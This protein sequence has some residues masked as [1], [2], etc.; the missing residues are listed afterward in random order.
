MGAGGTPV[1]SLQI[2]DSRSLLA[3]RQISR[4]LSQIWAATVLKPAYS[5]GRIIDFAG[6]FQEKSQILADRYSTIALLR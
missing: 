3:Q 5:C 6:A 4:H 1:S 2:A